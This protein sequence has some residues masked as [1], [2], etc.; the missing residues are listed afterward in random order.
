MATFEIFDFQSELF[1]TAE[2]IE[3]LHCVIGFFFV[4]YR[5]LKC[6]HFD[7]CQNC[8]FSGR[9]CRSH[10]LTHPM[11]E[12]CSNVS[13][14]ITRLS[15]AVVVVVVVVDL[16]SASR[17]ASNALNVPLR[18]KKMSFQSR[19]EAVGTPSRVPE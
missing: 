8:F 11:Q 5:C 3:L 19:F 7:M 2:R 15:A 13:L 12:Y 9:R 6:F 4:R 1:K 10:K 14:V 17:S 16:Y 18:R